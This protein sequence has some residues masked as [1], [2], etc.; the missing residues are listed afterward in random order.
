[1]C[2]LI[3]G[4]GG[5]RA[6]T[7]GAAGLHRSYRL[8][9]SPVPDRGEKFLKTTNE[10]RQENYH[11][12]K[13]T[14]EGHGEEN[15]HNMCALE[16][17]EGSRTHG[18]LQPETEGVLRP[19]PRQEYEGGKGIFFGQVRAKTTRRHGNSKAKP[20][21]LGANSRRARL[22]AGARPLG[23]AMAS[24]LSRRFTDQTRLFRFKSRCR[25]LLYD[26]NRRSGRTPARPLL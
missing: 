4:S 11:S 17:D 25:Q 16:G 12:G 9:D 21:D 7:L 15:M 20:R 19:P 14:R 6:S 5:H 3:D 22:R 1:M 26:M 8:P 24:R 13:E 23:R 18:D 2:R 10:V